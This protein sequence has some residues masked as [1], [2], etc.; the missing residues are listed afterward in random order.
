MEELLKSIQ[1]I[2]SQ[3]QKLSLALSNAV[4]YAHNI[5]NEADAK[6]KAAE[7]R[8]EKN[9][10]ES[11]SL[12]AREAK[13]KKIENIVV[14]EESLKVLEKKNAVELDNLEAMRS[15]FEKAS[16]ETLKDIAQ[17]TAKLADDNALLDRSWKDLRAKEKS[18]RAEI[19]DEIMRRFKK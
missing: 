11:A 12:A 14:L 2:I 9:A 8:E 18:Y 4:N 3:A 6:I 7:N 1:D 15:A 17:K 19:E 5:Q 16:K 10:F 13:V